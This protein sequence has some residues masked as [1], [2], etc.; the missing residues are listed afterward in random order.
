[1]RP[2]ETVLNFISAINARHIDKIV[3]L[4]TPDHFFVD[5]LGNEIR[6]RMAMRSA[7][8]GYFRIVPDYLITAE[9]IY[10]KGDSVVVVGSAAGTYAPDGCP[11]PA[12][13]WRV[14]AVWKAVVMSGRVR[15]WHIFADNGP[16]RS[17]MT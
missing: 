1:M 12:N 7:W 5:G 14:P 16:L 17:M 2:E 13:R 10:T 11:L 8:V 4:M 6:G 9:E 15:S 3:E